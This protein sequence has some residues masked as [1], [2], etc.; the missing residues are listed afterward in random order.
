MK[1][2]TSTLESGYFE[3]KRSW[4]FTVEGLKKKK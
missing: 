4:V 2:Q 3:Q 1:L